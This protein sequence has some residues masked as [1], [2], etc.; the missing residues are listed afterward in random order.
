MQCITLMWTLLVS[1]Y[2]FTLLCCVNS[3]DKEDKCFFFDVVEK[4]DVKSS[5]D[6]T[7]IFSVKVR[8]EFQQLTKQLW[9]H[10]AV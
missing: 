10:Q 3:V 6:L 8:L 4:D 5:V 2:T 9:F 7:N 1:I